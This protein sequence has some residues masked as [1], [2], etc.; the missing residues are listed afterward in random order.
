MVKRIRRSSGYGQDNRSSHQVINKEGTLVQTL[1]EVEEI[2]KIK[3]DSGKGKRLVSMGLRKVNFSEGS[4]NLGEIV[5]FVVDVNR[6]NEARRLHLL[7][8]AK[9]ISET[10]G[11]FG[12]D[13]QK[14]ALYPNGGVKRNHHF[15]RGC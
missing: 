11:E 14:L 1:V 4:N 7:P 12:L 5:Y 13:N 15:Y 9:I 8:G 6:V 3:D 10:M 2:K